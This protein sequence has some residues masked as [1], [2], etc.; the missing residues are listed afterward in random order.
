[1]YR[2]VLPHEEEKTRQR[3][4][5]MVTSQLRKLGNYDE[6][7]GERKLKLTAE[8]VSDLKRY[9]TKIIADTLNGEKRVQRIRRLTRLIDMFEMP[10]SMDAIELVI[11]IANAMTPIDHVRLDADVMTE[12]ELVVL[13]GWIKEKYIEDLPLNGGVEIASRYDILRMQLNSLG[14]YR[15]GDLPKKWNYIINSELYRVWFQWIEHY[16]AGVAHE[17]DDLARFVRDHGNEHVEE[18]IALFEAIV[19]RLRL[20]IRGRS[21]L[22]AG[23]EEMMVAIVVN[24][25]TSL[26]APRLRGAIDGLRERYADVVDAPRE[27][28]LSPLRLIGEWTPVPDGTGN[29]II[30]IT[31]NAPTGGNEVDELPTSRRRSEQ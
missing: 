1:M 5:E 25:D 7:W 29:R 17:S 9:G 27:L 28:E 23:W 6:F 20:L 10:S 8:D 16:A 13:L 15:W 11:W 12:S 22:V 4:K 14:R 3:V 26:I 31:R 24:V 2:L 30:I 21:P 19:R 18:V